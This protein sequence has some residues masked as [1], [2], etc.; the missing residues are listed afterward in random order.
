VHRIGRTARAGAS[1]VGVTF[2]LHDQAKELVS[3]VGSLDLHRELELGGLRGDSTHPRPGARPPR[4]GASPRNGSA[5]GGSSNKGS[6][7]G[8]RPGSGSSRGGRGSSRSR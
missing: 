8:A 6:A 3:M 2:V 7:R 4:R 5:R 1:G